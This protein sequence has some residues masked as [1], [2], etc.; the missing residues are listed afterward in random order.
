MADK[1][2]YFLGCSGYFYKGWWGKFYPKDLK[3]S[4]WFSYYV[5]RFNTVEINATFYRMPKPS[6]IRRWYEN[7]P[8][9]FIFSVK[10]PRTITHYKKFRNTMEE[11]RNFCNL[12]KKN[13]KEKLACMLIQLPPNYQ[14]S[15]ENLSII[16]GQLDPEIKNVI[17]FRHKSWWCD[18]IYEQLKRAGVCFCTVSAP[19]L[20]EDLVVTANFIYIRFHGKDRWYRYNYS[21]E[22]LK[23]WAE[24]IKGGGFKTAYI[25]FNNDFNANAPYNCEKLRE[26]LK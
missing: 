15:K 3:M 20:P 2:E 18:E 8:E 23:E 1:R 21:D 4:E 19:K 25:Y 10:M 14:I 5:N 22:E 11:V 17:E 26:F 12:I 24:K 6:D 9:S 7:T 13:L 16:L